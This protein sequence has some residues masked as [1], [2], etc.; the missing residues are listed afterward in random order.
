MC[1]CCCGGIR[2]GC[3]G[4]LCDDA[5]CHGPVGFLCTRR[6]DSKTYDL[7]IES[8]REKNKGELGAIFLP[9]LNPRGGWFF[10]WRVDCGLRRVRVP[11]P[12]TH[13]V[14]LPLRPTLGEV[15]ETL[16][17]C[18]HSTIAVTPTPELAKNGRPGRRRVSLLMGGEGWRRGG[19]IATPT[20]GRARNRRPGGLHIG[21]MG[22]RGR[23][24]RVGGGL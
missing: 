12:T 5:H 23:K 10:F 1:F 22:G 24:R 3:R 19:T 18:T 21:E 17:T 9:H 15:I 13:I 6:V 14:G 4:P 8:N 16:R 2:F 7:K 11:F 20:R